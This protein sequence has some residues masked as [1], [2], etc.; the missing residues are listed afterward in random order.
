MSTQFGTKKSILS[1][2]S[3]SIYIIFLNDN[4]DS[5]CLQENL[6]IYWEI[7]Y[8]SLILDWVSNVISSKHGGNGFVNMLIKIRYENITS[9]FLQ[10]H[11]KGRQMTFMKSI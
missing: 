3:V 6:Y 2:F 9:F 10:N 11:F 4:H 5:G 7:T 8:N 1:L